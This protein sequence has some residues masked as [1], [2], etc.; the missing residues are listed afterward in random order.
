MDLFILDHFH[1][2]YEVEKKVNIE[3]NLKHSEKGHI[4]TYSA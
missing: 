4:L 1:I 2:S 3:E